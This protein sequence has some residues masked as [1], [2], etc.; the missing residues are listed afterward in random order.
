M[1]LSGCYLGFVGP[2]GALIRLMPTVHS[3]GGTWMTYASAMGC[4]HLI[5]G[6]PLEPQDWAALEGL[7]GPRMV[8]ED[9]LHAVAAGEALASDDYR[10]ELTWY[11][12]ARR[13]GT[14]TA[15]CSRDQFYL[16]LGFFHMI[17]AAFGLGAMQCNYL[18]LL[19]QGRAGCD[20]REHPKWGEVRFWLLQTECWG[21]LVKRL[22]WRARGPLMMAL[23]RGGG[24][25]T[26]KNMR[27][28]SEGLHVLLRVRDMLPEL[29]RAIVEFL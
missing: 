17:E 28:A 9:W 11:L 12:A 8:H 1:A 7:T 15:V 22:N 21:Y 26:R 4:T 14:T 2:E 13:T 24:P 3:L 16:E 29:R 18:G 5:A 20:V 23:A 6:S 25:R 19:L 27:T 10:Y